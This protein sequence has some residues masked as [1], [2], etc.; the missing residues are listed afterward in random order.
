MNNYNMYMYIR[1][2]IMAIRLL[3]CTCR[4]LHTSWC[5]VLCVLW[6]CFKR[7]FLLCM[8]LFNLIIATIKHITAGKANL[9]PRFRFPTDPVL[10]FLL[11]SIMSTY[12]HIFNKFTITFILI[13]WKMANLFHECWQLYCMFLIPHN[14][15]MR[16]SIYFI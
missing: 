16:A 11:F 12:T 7:V 9:I 10:Q 5:I 15:T 2:W 8:Y 14:C 4:R 1:V 6:L 3:P 13:Q